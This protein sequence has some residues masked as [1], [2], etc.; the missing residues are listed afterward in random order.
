M[1]DIVFY[2]NMF[3]ENLIEIFFQVSQEYL[4]ALTGEKSFDALLLFLQVIQYVR[5]PVPECTVV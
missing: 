3:I 2:D 4:A 5:E 1:W